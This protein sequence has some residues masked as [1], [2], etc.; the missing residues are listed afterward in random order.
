[1]VLLVAY[2]VHILR[3][4]TPDQKLS[5]SALARIAAVVPVGRCV[6]TDSSS[7]LLMSGRFTANRPDC[8]QVVDSF[9]TELA[10][11]NGRLDRVTQTEKLQQTWR[12]WLEHA[13]ILVLNEPDL[14]GAASADGWNQRLE[15][16]RTRALL[17]G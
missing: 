16:L 12:I 5:S 7:I 9:G 14:A 13:D 2:G 6:V 3:V 8:P 10:L 15:T 11:S 1:M 17:R 4:T